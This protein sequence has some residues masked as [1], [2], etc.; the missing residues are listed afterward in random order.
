[1]LALGCVVNLYIAHRSP[2]LKFIEGTTV[3]IDD[4]SPEDLLGWPTVPDGVINPDMGAPFQCSRFQLTT[5]WSDH[6]LWM[7]ELESNPGKYGVINLNRRRFGMPL[8]V[9]SDKVVSRQVPRMPIE[10]LWPVPSGE[11]H[12]AVTYHSLGLILNP[13]I[14]ALPFWLLMMGLR[15][16]FIAICSRKR[17]R[18][19]LCTSCGYDLTGLNVCPECGNAPTA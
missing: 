6:V 10:Y 2:S 13:I 7:Y 9:R 5:H 18:H 12:T 3:L 4:P 19:G 17:S 1:M 14:Y 8:T 11:R 16:A 15:W